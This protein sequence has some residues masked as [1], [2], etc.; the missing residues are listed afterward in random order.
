[1]YGNPLQ[2]YENVSKKTA[3]GR[4]VEAAVLCKAAFKLRECQSKWDGSDHEAR[5]DEALKFNQRIW[6]I[7]QGELSREDNPLPNDI[8]QNLARL[9]AFVDKRIIETMAYPSPE[10]LEIVIKINENIAAGLR[11][12]PSA[13]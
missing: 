2:T 8:Q 10:K 6:S 11:D 7:F 9:G 13:N 5:L 3:S 4:E 1:M 12:S